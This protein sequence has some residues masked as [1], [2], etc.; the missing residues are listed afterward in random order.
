MQHFNAFLW[1]L[2]MR[3]KKQTNKHPKPKKLHPW[4]LD[5]FFKGTHHGF[6][7][8]S[9]VWGTILVTNTNYA[10]PCQLLD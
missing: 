4:F 1:D 5:R 7:C 3:R 6:K 9:S 2:L 8:F 10:I